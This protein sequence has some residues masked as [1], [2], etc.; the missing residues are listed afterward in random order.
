MTQVTPRRGARQ[1]PGLVTLVRGDVRELAAIE[2]AALLAVQVHAQVTGCVLPV[3]PRP[4][5]ELVRDL[6]GDCVGRWT[7]WA[8]VADRAFEDVRGLVISGHTWRAAAR[9]V[10]PA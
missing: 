10:W 7:A 2:R 6:A 5:L 4:G 1:Q 8:D 3:P 9:Q